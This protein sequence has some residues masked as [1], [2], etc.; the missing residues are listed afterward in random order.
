ML[1]V[2]FKLFV[3]PSLMLIT[4]MISKRVF[5]IS[6]QDATE[7]CHYPE[8]LRETHRLELIFV[9]PQEHFTELIVLGER[10]SSFAADKI[11][12]LGKNFKWI[13]FLSSK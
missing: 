6:M 10:K 9:F 13:L 12:L 7:K 4:R 5:S 11:L 1:T 2:Q 8:L 3:L